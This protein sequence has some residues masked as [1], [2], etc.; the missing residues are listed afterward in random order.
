[1]EK[2]TEF[3]GIKHYFCSR[4]NKIHKKTM[5]VSNKTV[6]CMPFKNCQEF[7][8]KLSSTEIWHRQ[9]KHSTEAYNIKK[10]KE[11][12]GSKKQ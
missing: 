6:F 3:N 5:R 8:Y 2:I 11:S 1:M 7:A 12:T 4:C 9:F 10:H